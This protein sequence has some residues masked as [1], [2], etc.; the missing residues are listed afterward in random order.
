MGSLSSFGM[1]I[2]CALSILGEKGL[3]EDRKLKA[4]KKGDLSST[5]KVL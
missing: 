1:T 2:M 4:P 5:V 3:D